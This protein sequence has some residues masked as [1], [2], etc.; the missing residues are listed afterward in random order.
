MRAATISGYSA[1]IEITELA[2]PELKDD[3][4]LVEVRAA[5]PLAGLT[6]S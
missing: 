3:S 2:K 6:A 5:V 1:P 4:V